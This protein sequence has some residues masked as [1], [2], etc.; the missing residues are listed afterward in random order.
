M[1][2]SE[3]FW[4]RCTPGGAASLH[5]GRIGSWPRNCLL[6]GLWFAVFHLRRLAATYNAAI[7]AFAGNAIFAAIYYSTQRS[8]KREVKGTA[9][10]KMHFGDAAIIV[11]AAITL[12]LGHQ[13]GARSTPSS[14][15][16]ID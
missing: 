16:P 8:A 7:F 2:L 6:V 1:P 14:I 11:S 3:N 10:D 15:W 5:S 4:S 12:H 9:L 13:P